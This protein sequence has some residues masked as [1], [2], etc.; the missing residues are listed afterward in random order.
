MMK[1]SR[2]GVVCVLMA[3]I[4]ALGGCSGEGEQQGVVA[5]VNGRPITLDRLELKY[6]F[7]HLDSSFDAAPSV[8]QLKEDYGHLLGDLIVQ[9][10]VD[11]ELERRDL[12]VTQEEVQAAE[13]E[14]RADYPE[15]TFEQVLVEEYIDIDYWRQ[16]L[17]ARLALEKFFSEVLRPGISLGYEE[18]EAYYRQHINEFYLPPRLRI[19]LVSGPSRDAV[20]SAVDL[21]RKNSSVDAIEG[22]FEQVEVRELRVR[23]DRMTIAWKNALKPLSPGDATPVMTSESD[24]Q[25]LIYL[26]KSPAKVLDPSRAYPVVEKVLVERKLREAF[27]AWLS[28]ALANAS[29]EV[30]THLLDDHGMPVQDD[31]AAEPQPST[32]PQSAAPAKDESAAENATENATSA[33]AAA[34]AEEGGKKAEK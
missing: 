30:S 8:A 34:T 27:D 28:D 29:I 33:D 3:L 11:E 12:G 6:D 9:E 1:N 22:K 21:Y 20:Q 24:F 16:E 32:A 15:D 4:F 25:S 7:M 31:A 26:E 23:E 10:L 17:R 2:I 5:R 14:V 19:Y 13:D 18:A